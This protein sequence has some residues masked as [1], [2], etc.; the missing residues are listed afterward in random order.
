MADQR[1]GIALSGGGH[2]AASWAAGAVLGLTDAGVAGDVVSVAS[3]SGGSIANG[4]VATGGDLR[5]GD[6]AAVEGW[7]RPGLRR[8]AHDGLFFNGPAT[9]G[10]V[11]MTLA[12]AVLAV[13]GVLAAAAATLGAGRE[14]ADPSVAWVTIGIGVPVMAVALLAA[15][16]V[17]PGTRIPAAVLGAAALSVPLTYV[18][19]RSATRAAWSLGIVW[20]LVAI[21]LLAAA[22]RFGGRSQAVVDALDR[23]LFAATPTLASLAARPV[24]HVFCATNLRTGNNLYL[25]NRVV[26]GYPVVGRRP[27]TETLATAVQASACLPGGFLARSLDLVDG[28]GT[29]RVVLSDGGVYDNMADQWEWGFENRQSYAGQKERTVL[30]RAQPQGATHLVVVN[31]SKGMEGDDD[32]LDVQPGL[33]GE[34]TSLTSAINVLYDVSTAPRRSRLVQEFDR[35]GG[36]DGMLVHIGTSPYVVIDRFTG[37]KGPLGTRARA[38][39]RLLGQLTDAEAG[40]KDD[41]RR[42]AW[43]AD[44]ARGERR[45]QD[46]AGPAG[47]PRT[48]LDGAAPPPRLGAHPRH[49]PRPARVGAAPAVGRRG[50]AARPVRRARRVGPG[51]PDLRVTSWTHTALAQQVVFGDGAVARLPDLL[52]TLG[53]R[54]AH[55]RHDGRTSRRRPTASRVVSLLGRSLVSTFSDVTSHVPAP[56]VQAALLQARRDAIDAVVSFGGGSCADLG[57]AVCFFLEQEAGV[58]GASHVDRPAV[59]PPQ[60][61]HHLLGRRAHARSSA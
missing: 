60:H 27:E 10:W 39:E 31:A 21:G 55:A 32:A 48:G 11:A 52:R 54:R 1:I 16:R 35:P 22:R 9:D 26:W 24:H 59:A 23:E 33:V 46:H 38:A 49:R 53:A 41:K 20:A 45:R 57:K 47:G 17:L 43:W 44:V 25:S 3:V 56:T 19:V 50:L 7:L 40:T 42:R 4:V 51:R 12:A 8:W 18:L 58:P 61:P 15:L 28:N 34:L 6:R 5:A 14:W 13:L 30:D 36:L 37:A 29:V 2:R